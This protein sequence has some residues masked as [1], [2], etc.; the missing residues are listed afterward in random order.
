MSDLEKYLDA[1]ASANYEQLSTFED[2]FTEYPDDGIE[3]A[4]L[5]RDSAMTEYLLSRGVVEYWRP[6]CAATRVAD[7]QLASSLL[8]R[9]LEQEEGVYFTKRALVVKMSENA[10]RTGNLGAIMFMIENNIGIDTSAVHS[11]DCETELEMMEIARLLINRNYEKKNIMRM[12]ARCGCLITTGY[13][14]TLNVGN[15]TEVVK[16]AMSMGHVAIARIYASK[17][18][19]TLEVKSVEDVNKAFGGSWADYA[20]VDNYKQLNF[21][22]PN[23]CNLLIKAGRFKE[24]L[25]VPC[26]DQ[27]QAL[28]DLALHGDVSIFNT[29]AAQFTVTDEDKW[30]VFEG[31]V[32]GRNNDMCDHL[33]DKWN[34]DLS[35]AVDVAIK[36]NVLSVVNSLKDN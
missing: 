24:A 23:E 5:K 11:Y 19:H 2:K 14:D 18:D 15:Y 6:I 26:T 22:L 10:I 17:Y 7:M 21:D 8:N 25:L 35:T 28:Y 20:T 31:A 16:E 9:F 4:I 34:L 29:F 1:V 32:L 36:F 30:T 13:L 12:T 33:V 27:V 3:V